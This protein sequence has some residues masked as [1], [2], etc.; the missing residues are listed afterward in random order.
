MWSDPHLWI[1]EAARFLRLG[2]ELIFITNSIFIMLFMPDEDGLF[3]D[4][5]LERDYFGIHRLE[6]PDDNTVEFHLNHGDCIRLLRENGFEI[7]DLIEPRP[8]A[9]TVKMYPYV[10]LDWARRWPCE[11][12]WK[13]RKKG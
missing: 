13:V 4:T 5:I 10:T 6:W 7:I 2:G 8:A 9:D 11:E 3:A 12:V 1:P